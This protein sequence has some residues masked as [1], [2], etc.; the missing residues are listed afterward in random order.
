MYKNPNPDFKLV[1][2]SRAQK[3]LFLHEI[4][5]QLSDGQWENARPFDHFEIWCALQDH[6][7]LI[8]PDTSKIGRNFYPRRDRYALLNSDFLKVLESRMIVMCRLVTAF[9]FDVADQLV[10]KLFNWIGECTY[11]G[12]GRSDSKLDIEERAFAAKFDLAEIK[13]IG[14]D[15]TLYNG[16]MLRADLKQLA[17]AMRTYQSGK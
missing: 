8:N 2:G 13:R 7:V 15:S 12:P 14:E 11:S 9:D 16:K 4:Q 1:V 10:M 6:Q 3:M 5:G 17:L